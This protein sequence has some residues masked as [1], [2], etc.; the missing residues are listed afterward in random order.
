[1]RVNVI[2][3]PFEAILF[4]TLFQGTRLFTTEF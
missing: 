3:E 2:P 1:M 4:C